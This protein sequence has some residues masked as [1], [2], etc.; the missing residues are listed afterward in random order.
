M[1]NVK[2]LT[3]AEL[4]HLI[5]EAADAALN[6]IDSKTSSRIENPNASA[7]DHIQSGN[8]TE[9]I[10]TP[11][12]KKPASNG[13]QTIRTDNLC[14]PAIQS[15][16]T[17]YK[18]FKFMFFTFRKE[19]N[20]VHFLFELDDIKNLLDNTVIL[21]GNV[22]FANTRLPGDIVINFKKGQDGEA[23]YQ[24]RGKGD[25][26]ILTPDNRTASKWNELVQGLQ[27]YLTTG[28]IKN[29]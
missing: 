11:S 1:K 8:Y 10:N 13:D 25:K 28:C 14:P 26:Y 3:E 9:T 16:L 7:K 15:F 5:Q 17:P 20:V 19:G 2:I 22:T 24:Y 23:A 21:S 4:K 6:E 29:S 12:R 27:D 18:S